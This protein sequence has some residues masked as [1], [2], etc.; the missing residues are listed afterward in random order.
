MPSNT[1]KLLFIFLIL[2]GC[3]N[4]SDSEMMN[5]DEQSQ[6]DQ[7]DNNDNDEDSSTLPLPTSDLDYTVL[8]NWAIHPDKATILS[9]YDLDISVVEKDLSVSS[10]IDIPNNSRTD[11]GI[12][13]FFVH[14]TLL[15]AGNGV[16]ANV[17]LD[18]Q[19]ALRISNTIIAQGGLLSKYGR[20]FAPRYRQSTGITYGDS[21]DK[22]TQAE[23]I[24]VSYSDIKAAF[25]EYMTSYNNGN[26]IILAGH[27]QGSYLLS[28][29]IR[30]VFDNDTAM[31]DQLLTA[32][33]GG[34][35]F[36]YGTPNTYVGGQF[37]NISLCTT[38]DECGCIHSWRAY[39]QSQT[40]PEVRSGLPLFNEI[41]VDYGLYYRTLDPDQDWCVQDK[42]YYTEEASELRYI[43]LNPGLDIEGVETNFVAFDN[44]YTG[45]FRRDG[46]LIIGLGVQ[47]AA[48]MDDQRPDD[49]EE[50]ENDPLFSFWG[51]HTKDYHIYLTALMDQID[52]KLENCN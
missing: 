39:E 42:S 27:S 48:D 3:S 33:L 51:Y 21:T 32:A 2:L 37:E 14:P 15:D 45:K 13:I 43:G 6:E 22:E 23:V 52:A 40:I 19:P 30:D 7:D 17:P 16:A 47:Y 35:G 26:K 50:E 9:V 34:M 41:L 12:D 38:Q 24:T 20:M 1:L 28:M 25:L 5:D 31:Q 49:L 4:D 36:V 11:T 29:L 8:S 18:E 10:V 44:M 46:N